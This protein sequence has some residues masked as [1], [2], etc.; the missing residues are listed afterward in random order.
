M[1]FYLVKKINLMVIK[2]IL[3]IMKSYQPYYNLILSIIVIK[4]TDDKYTAMH[5]INTNRKKYGT[6]SIERDDRQI[7]IL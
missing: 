6:I 2:I 4:N 1:K 7:A 3:K 5:F